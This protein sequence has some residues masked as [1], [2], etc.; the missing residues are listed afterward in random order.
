M[1]SSD[2]CPS[3]FDGTPDSGC[4]TQTPSVWTANTPVECSMDNVDCLTTTCDASSIDAFFREDLFHVNSY[5]TGSFMDQ[6]AADIRILKRADTGA[7]LGNEATPGV[8]CGYQIVNGGI[9]INWDYAACN[10][11]PT[12]E[13]GKIAY[14]VKIQAFGN[15]AEPHPMIEFYV[16]LSAEA[17]CLYDPEVD[18]SASFWVN[19]E[20]VA[21]DIKEKGKFDDL[22]DCRFFTDEKR[23]NQILDH[24]I[25]NMGERLWGLVKVKKNAGYGL[26]YKLKTVRFS[27]A[28]GGTGASIEV[29][30]GP[31]NSGR[32]NDLMSTEVRRPYVLP[33]TKNQKFNFLSFGFENLTNQQQLD[34]KCRIKIMLDP[35]FAAANNGPLGMRSFGAMGEDFIEDAPV[36]GWGTNDYYEEY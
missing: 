28:T 20:D 6:L 4:Y 8:T 26:K 23:K 1:T 35:K 27:D 25:V 3:K 33:F 2:I 12:M 18:V 16:D 15:D 13:S 21:M 10:V 17:T 24:N 19:Q 31:G 30:G 11:A 5:H 14:G 29:V 9:R 22:F 36:A 7:I 34:V 32:G